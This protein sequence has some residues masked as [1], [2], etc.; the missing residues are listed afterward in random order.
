VAKK[1]KAS[2]APVLDGLKGKKIQ[3]AGGHTLAIFKDS[4]YPQDAF[5]LGEFFNSD[6]ALDVLFKEVGWLVGKSTWLKKI[7]T[8]AYPG[9]D[10]YFK[11]ANEATDWYE[12][13]RCPLH[14]FIWGQTQLPTIREQIYR[15]KITAKEGCAQLQKMVETEW[16]NQGLPEPTA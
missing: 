8:N 10:F 5:K 9:L 1:N 16:K 11:S 3:V 13:R 12:L 15:G 7:D 4:K 2:W 14:G 6:A